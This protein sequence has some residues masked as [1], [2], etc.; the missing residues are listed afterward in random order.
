MREEFS[1]ELDRG[2]INNDGDKTYNFYQELIIRHKSHEKANKTAFEIFHSK[3]KFQKYSYQEIYTFVE[4]KSK[5]WF[6]SDLGKGSIITF[7]NVTGIDLLVH[8]MAALNLGCIFSVLTV[9]PGNEFSETLFDTRLQ[10]ISPDIIVIDIDIESESD[11]E[12]KKNGALNWRTLLSKYKSCPLEPINTRVDQSLTNNTEDT[13]NAED[14]NNTLNNDIQYDHGLRHYAPDQIVCINFDY[15]SQDSCKAFYITAQNLYLSL[16]LNAGEQLM[17]LQQGDIL[18]FPD[19]SRLLYQP[20]FILTSLYSGIHYLEA[21]GDL[22]NV[23]ARGKRW[24]FCDDKIFVVVL[25]P[26]LRDELI[27]KDKKMSTWRSCFIVEDD[28]VKNNETSDITEKKWKTFKKKCFKTLKERTLFHWQS[29]LSGFSLI[30]QKASEGTTGRITPVKG[31]EFKLV[32]PVTQKDTLSTMGLFSC[33][34]GGAATYVTHHG[35]MQQEQEYVR[36]TQNEVI[37]DGRFYPKSDLLHYLNTVFNPRDNLTVNIEWVNCYFLPV[38]LTKKNH[39]VLLVFYCERF[40]QQ[41]HL[42]DNQQETL[43]QETINQQKKML[44][45]EINAKIREALGEHFLPDE[46]HCYFYMPREEVANKTNGINSQYLMGKLI[47]KSNDKLFRLLSVYR[48]LISDQT[49]IVS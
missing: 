12:S 14:R 29:V 16:E 30:E 39:L 20:G 21:H 8:M 34:I 49:K 42:P 27:D 35:L 15:D 1:Q 17:D 37:R 3:D 33:Q 40:N 38:S 48:H 6:E 7:V 25:T 32:D 45:K 4:E 43:E 41:A 10:L 46:T 23:F 13:N 19:L 24:F 2:S 47:K 26:Q 18:L 11:S 31:R 36:Y 9:K 28:K 22:D 5:S 44:I